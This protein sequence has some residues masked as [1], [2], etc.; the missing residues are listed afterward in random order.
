VPVDAARSRGRSR[1]PKIDLGTL[2]S[3]L[4]VSKEV[5]VYDK[6]DADPLEEKQGFAIGGRTIALIA[7]AAVIVIFIAQNTNDVSIDFLFFHGDWP[8]WLVVVAVIALTLIAERLGSWIWRRSRK[9]KG[10]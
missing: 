9:D 3:T 1:G 5:V 4:R 2:G 10:S 6:G 8:L 7:I